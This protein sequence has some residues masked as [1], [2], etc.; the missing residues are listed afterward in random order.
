MGFK[1][2]GD[3]LQLQGF[4]GECLQAYQQAFMEELTANAEQLGLKVKNDFDPYAESFNSTTGRRQVD[5]VKSYG[6]E[7]NLFNPQY[8]DQLMEAERKL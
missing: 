3:Y 6:E 1:Q 8:V 2:N 7:K 5:N 4:N